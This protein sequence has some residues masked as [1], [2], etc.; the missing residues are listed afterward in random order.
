MLLFFQTSTPI[1][2]LEHFSPFL[3][4]TSIKIKITDTIIHDPDYKKMEII[5]DCLYKIIGTDN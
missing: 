4:T 2:F 5:K 3:N 1:Q